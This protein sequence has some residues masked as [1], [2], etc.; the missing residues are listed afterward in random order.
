MKH[1]KAN[2]GDYYW[3][4]RTMDNNNAIALVRIKIVD[5]ESGDLLYG[6]RVLCATARD[7]EEPARRLFDDSEAVYPFWTYEAFLYT[8]VEGAM[9]AMQ[10]NIEYGIKDITAFF[11][12][13]KEKGMDINSRNQ[14]V[15]LSLDAIDVNKK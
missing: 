11:E 5:M 13:M 3:T 1:I 9:A 8:T 6:R 4:I 2:I 15:V 7:P 14:I 12:M 10:K